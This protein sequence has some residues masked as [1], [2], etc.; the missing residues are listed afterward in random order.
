MYIKHLYINNNLL[1]YKMAEILSKIRLASQPAA[2]WD[3]TLVLLLGQKGIETDTNLEKTGDGVTPWSALPYLHV[4]AEDIVGGVNG[5]DGTVIL[6]GTWDASMG[7]FPA[8]VGLKRGWAYR[9]SFGGTVDGVTFL[10]NDLLICVADCACADSATK[11]IGNWYRNSDS[12]GQQNTSGLEVIVNKS[13]SVVDDSGSNV[14]YPTVKS[15]YDWGNSSFVTTSSEQTL[16]NKRITYRVGSVTSSSTPSIN[17][18]MYDIY[19]ITALDTNITSMSVNLTGT[20]T[21]EQCLIINITGTGSRTIDWG[22][23]F[24]S[25]TVLL[26]NS[27]EGT[28][29]LSIGL[30][31]NSS[32][33]KWRCIGVS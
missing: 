14:R 9:V 2:Q 13:T 30:M 1:E 17:T 26:P 22:N 19:N 5:A 32:T 16:T 10:T 8:P 23:L 21:S 15:V 4:R 6:K 24:E 12:T 27:T 31:Y 18:N 33:G 25:S 3:P 29:K 20:P 28:N 11:Y 7:S